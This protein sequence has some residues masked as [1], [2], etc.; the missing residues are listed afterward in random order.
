MLP[1]TGRSTTLFPFSSFQLTCNGSSTIYTKLALPNAD[2]SNLYG[3]AVVRSSKPSLSLVALSTTTGE[4]QYSTP[5]PSS[6]VYIS[7][8]RAHPQLLLPE[9]KALVW[10]EQG[11][12]HIKY[13]PLLPEG[14]TVK[15][16]KPHTFK[17]DE[18]YDA[19][20]L[21]GEEGVL[22]GVTLLGKVDA[23]TL[24]RASL[25]LAYVFPEKNSDAISFSSYTPHGK[26]SVSSRIIETETTTIL[27][28]LSGEQIQ[29]PLDVPSGIQSYTLLPNE[30]PTI[31]VTSSSGSITLYSG[32]TP[33]WERVEGFSSAKPVFLQLPEPP[34]SIAAAS[35]EGEWFIQRVIRHLTVSLPQFV[36]SVAQ[37]ELISFI[38]EAPK[39]D[40][41]LYKDPF[42]FRQLILK[43]TKTGLVVAI[44]GRD[45]TVVWKLAL[46]RRVTDEQL[47]VMDEPSADVFLVGTADDGTFDGDK[48]QFFIFPAPCLWIA[49]LKHPQRPFSIGSMASP[50]SSYTKRRSLRTHSS[51]RISLPF[52]HHR[53]RRS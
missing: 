14:L 8:K 50:A 53:Q 13:L 28:L 25:K 26:P 48:V 52:H 19:L 2:S 44:D 33:V 16:A 38:E 10:L 3:I 30:I 34:S 6:N 36:M 21:I 46:G 18:A 22:S 5:I 4:L 31:L 43:T 45:G 1:Q 9:S 40:E 7:R 12:G 37:I 35:H 15:K 24:D 47:L 39:V 49:I 17:T 32:A 20:E 41:G 27:E 23:F 42:S 29:L 11:T 51:L